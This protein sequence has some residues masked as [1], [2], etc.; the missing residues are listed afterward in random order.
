MHHVRPPLLPLSST[1]IHGKASRG[2]WTWARSNGDGVATGTR[3]A[4]TGSGGVCGRRVRGWVAACA[5]AALRDWSG[6]LG[7]DRE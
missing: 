2:I 7:G 6:I 3:G 5:A 4:M 1:R